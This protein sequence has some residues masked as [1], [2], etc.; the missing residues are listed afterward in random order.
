MR[1]KAA[2]TVLV[3]AASR[4]GLATDARPRE[5]TLAL[6]KPTV[7][8]YTPHILHALRRLRQ[9]EGLEV[10]RCTHQILRATS[11]T[12]TEADAARFYAEHQ[13]KFYYDRLI[14][15]MTAGRAVGLALAGPDAIR[16]WRALIGPTKAYR[17]AWE[18]PTTLR[19]ELGLGDTRNGFHGS[20]ATE[21]ALRELALVFPEWDAQQWLT[22][23]K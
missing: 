14:L 12:W 9:N 7:C 15:G 1:P 6:I 19:A 21:S 16:A 17:A 4:R 11:F 5:L 3:R 2:V 23:Q 10:G 8:A 22:R 13:G 18:A 20:D